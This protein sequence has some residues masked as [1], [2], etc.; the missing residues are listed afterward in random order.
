MKRKK[1]IAVIVAIVLVVGAATGGIYGYKTYQEKKL[2]AEVT[3]VSNLSTQYWGDENTSSGMVTNNSSQEVY[4]S[5]AESVSEV[6]VKEGDTVAVGDPLISYDMESVNIQ[7]KQKELDISNIENDVAI[8]QRKL[9]KLKT[10]TPVDKTKPT[11]TTPT[12]EEPQPEA[13]Q[14]PETPQVPE[15][16]DTGAYNYVTSSTTPS[17][18]EDEPDGSAEKPYVFLC[19]T[20]AYVTGNYLNTL[21][22]DKK[23]AVFEVRKGDV[24]TGELI[25]SWTIN[26]AYMTASYEDE[27]KYDI[28]THEEK[29]DSMDDG[30]DNGMDD[31]VIDDSTDSADDWVEP[32]GYSAEELAKAI[33]DQEAELKTLDINKRKAEL[34]LESLQKTSEDGTLYATVAGTVKTVG[35]PEDYTNDGTAFLVVA[36]SDGLYVTGAV[37]EFLLDEVGVGTMVTANSWESGMSFEAEITE[38]S[39]YPTDTQDYYGE[40]N[41]N[42]SYYPYTAYIEDTTGLKNGEYVSLSITTGGDTSDALFIDKSYVRT[43]DGQSYVMVAGEDDKL[44]K[45]YVGTGRT[46]YNYAIEI[47]S[48]LSLEDR[49]AFPY[50]KTAVEGVSVTDAEDSYYY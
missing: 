6:Y 5:D 15:K 4:L 32:E 31:T 11:T 33:S 27:T 20:G 36:S 37:S 50:G 35:D 29:D 17:N 7:I 25:A 38:I 34:E 22:N 23:S 14:V 8:A 2:V 1:V 39:D 26:G 48:G 47:T 43:E 42:C 45:R 16:T 19:S 46:I 41:T 40:G 28:L 3:P 49:I 30:T 24:E 21:T 10:T 18:A 9:D 13:P 44:E 12:V